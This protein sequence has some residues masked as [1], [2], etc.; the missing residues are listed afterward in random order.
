MLLYN[1]NIMNPY[2]LAFGIGYYYGRA[3]PRDEMPILAEADMPYAGTYGF[4]AGLERGR[5]DF[6]EIDL[7]VAAETQDPVDNL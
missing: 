3:Y 1:I 6:E 7:V 4:I 5:R 2:T